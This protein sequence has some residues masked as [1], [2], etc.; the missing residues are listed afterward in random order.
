M[1]AFFTSVSTITSVISRGSSVAA[2]YSHCAVADLT[3]TAATLLHIAKLREHI[4]QNGIAAFGRHL[5]QIPVLYQSAIK[6]TAGRVYHQAVVI[7]VNMHFAAQ[8]GIVAVDERVTILQNLPVSHF[9]LLSP[10]ILNY[11]FSISN[12]FVLLPLNF[13]EYDI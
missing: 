6:H 12:Y 9:S 5:V 7:D 11:P 13:Y 2:R 8:N 4:C 3:Q 1:R 10:I